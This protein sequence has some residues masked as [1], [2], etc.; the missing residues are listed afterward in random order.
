MYATFKAS[1]QRRKKEERRRGGKWAGRETEKGSK[2]EGGEGGAA[3]QPDT[4]SHCSSLRSPENPQTR[5]KTPKSRGTEAQAEGG[6]GHGMFIKRRTQLP[7]QPLSLS[8]SFHF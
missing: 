2:K 3:T 8:L 7:A 1:R 4:A 6:K 5:W